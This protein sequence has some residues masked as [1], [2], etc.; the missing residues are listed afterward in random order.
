MSQLPPDVHRL[1][2]AALTE[3]QVFCDPTTE[4]LVPTDIL[5]VGMVRA[6]APGVL[7][8]VEVALAVFRKVESQ[9]D[10]RALLADGSAVNPGD[11]IARVE[12]PAGA[13]WA[14]QPGAEVPRAVMAGVR[15]GRLA[16]TTGAGV[17]E[18]VTEVGTALA[19]GSASVSQTVPTVAV[20][21]DGCRDIMR[22]T[23]GE[24]SSSLD[25]MNGKRSECRLSRDDMK[26]AKSQRWK[27]PAMIR[28]AKPT[29]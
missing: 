29:R 9:L 6:K 25:T 23:R 1:V 10:A 26:Y 15:A 18:V 22:H 20:R 8:G 21:A 19:S 27:R 12:G 11:D 2:D 16:V 14:L 4:A 17:T 13:Y 5:A 24:Y 28:R 3:D 7:A